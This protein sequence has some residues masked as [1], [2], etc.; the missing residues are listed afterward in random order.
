MNQKKCSAALAAAALLALML[1]ACTGPSGD[2]AVAAARKKMRDAASLDAQ[3]ET[4]TQYAPSEENAAALTVAN[5]IEVT[6]F[7][8]PLKLRAHVAL[9][10]ASGEDRMDQSVTM[11]ALQNG[12]SFTQYAT[13]GEAWLKKAVT[14]ET[15]GDYDA[16]DTLDLYLSSGSGYKKAGEELVGAS[17]A[18]KY[19]GSVSGEPLVGLLEDGGFL[20]SISSMSQAQQ[21]KIKTNLKKLPALPIHVW[22]DRESGCPA[23]FELDLT[24]VLKDAEASMSETLGNLDTAS[25]GSGISSATVRMTCSNFGS[26]ADFELPAEAASAA[27]LEEIGA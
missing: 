3:I 13:N 18:D 16:R 12:E 20:S 6:M 5:R 23:R 17:A 11:Y 14:P 1:S 19:T 9:E 22:V 8:D 4:L 2:E 21:E 26:A 10:M 25:G 27:D 15:L 24:Q 7:T